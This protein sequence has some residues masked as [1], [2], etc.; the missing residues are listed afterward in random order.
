MDIGEVIETVSSYSGSSSTLAAGAYSNCVKDV[1]IF[2][3]RRTLFAWKFVCCVRGTPP[4]PP[5]TIY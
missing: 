5:Y 2:T 1:H 3:P 4:L